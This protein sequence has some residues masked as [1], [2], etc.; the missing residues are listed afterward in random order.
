MID[1]DSTAGLK[2]KSITR[3]TEKTRKGLGHRQA[4]K[5]YLTHYSLFGKN[6][7]QTKRLNKPP[8]LMS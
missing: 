6:G 3:R 8:R 2:N 1:Y 7:G 5:T 4:Y